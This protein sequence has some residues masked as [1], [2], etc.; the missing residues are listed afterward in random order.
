MAALEK[1]LHYVSFETTSAD[2]S[3][4]YPSTL[5]QL[6]LA[7]E[8]KKELEEMGTSNVRM[9]EY[10]YVM[11]EVPATPGYENAPAIG[12]IAHMDTSN[13]APGG[14]IKPAIVKNYDGGTILLNEEKNITMSPED[15]PTLREN[16]G[17][18]LVVTDG[19]TLLGGDDKAGIAIIMAAAER[20]LK[21]EVPHGRVCI[22]FTPDEE[23]GGGTDHFDIAD[24]NADFAYTLDGGAMGEIEY[25][26]F[27]AASAE[28]VVHG[29]SIHPGSSKNKMINALLVGIEFNSMLPG[30]EIPA[31]TEGYEGF[32]H[33]MFMNGNEE[34]TVLKYIIR[35]HDMEKFTAKKKLFEKV[36]A[37]M[38]EKYGYEIVSLTLKDSYYNMKSLFEGHMDIIERANEAYRACGV[39]NP[40]SVPIRGGTD[41]ARLS[42]DGL[43]CPNL[44]TG[45]YNYHGRFEYV[46]IDYMEKMVDVVMELVKVK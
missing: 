6:V 31:H 22:G 4:T 46:S 16:V 43:L 12:L 28:V 45:G 42:Y 33:L 26:N 11:A 35:D 25:E 8:L 30:F 1:L 5:T 41:G 23:V 36:A 44:S 15:F 38:N 40:H 32:Q 29:R 17:Q 20:L 3:E 34:E 10:G 7:K 24:F 9:S 14:N 39:K 2:N 19:T 27:N 18:D 21:N 13:A 37:Y